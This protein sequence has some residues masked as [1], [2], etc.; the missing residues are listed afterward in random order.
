MSKYVFL[1]L[2]FLLFFDLNGQITPSIIAHR[3]AKSIAPENTLSAFA[4]DS[5]TRVFSFSSVGHEGFIRGLIELRI[6]SKLSCSTHVDHWASFE[7]LVAKF[8]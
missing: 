7:S 4:A 2:Q 3:G 1:I 8:A 6:V 5:N